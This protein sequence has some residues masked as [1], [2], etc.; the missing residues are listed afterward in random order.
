M[1]VKGVT[2]VV[3]TAILL[4]IAIASVGTASVFLDDLVESIQEAL[5]SDLERE[6]RIEQSEISIITVYNNSE[7][8]LGLTVENTGSITLDI[9]EDGVKIWNVYTDGSPAEDWE[10]V[11]DIERLDPV[12]LVEIEVEEGFPEDGEETEIEVQAQYES[13][14][15]Y[16]CTGTG[17]PTC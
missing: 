12:E 16:I 17:E 14:A 9:E 5:E 8:E 7:G 3:A 1:K 10:T 2:P 15:R 6:E 4:F 11:D 13:S